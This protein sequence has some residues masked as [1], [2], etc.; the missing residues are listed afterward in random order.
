[1]FWL[2]PQKVEFYDD[3]A[4]RVGDVGDEGWTID[5]LIADIRTNGLQNPIE[6][7][8]SRVDLKHDTKIYAFNGNHRLAACQQLGLRFILCV[9]S[10]SFDAVPL[11]FDD[12]VALGGHG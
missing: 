3:P 9:N 10:D 7:G 5:E 1:V 6:V 4:R 11:T 2:S 12:V 8:R